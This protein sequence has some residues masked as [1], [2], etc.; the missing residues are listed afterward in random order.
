M[1]HHT[2]AHPDAPPAEHIR[3]QRRPLPPTEKWIILLLALGSA[4]MLFMSVL[5]LMTGTDPATI[6]KALVIACSAGLVAYGG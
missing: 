5:H 4:L 3:H 1:T 6:L 2:D